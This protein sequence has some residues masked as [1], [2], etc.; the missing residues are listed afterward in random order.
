MKVLTVQQPWA[1][2]IL[3]LGK[4]IENRKWKTKYRG[5]L[6][7]HA[8]K[9]VQGDWAGDAIEAITGK[10]L[11]IP[12][13]EL[14]LGCVV[15]IVDLVD[16]RPIGDTQSPW[17]MPGQYGWVLK[18]P[19]LLHPSPVTGKLLLWD[20]ADELIDLLGPPKAVKAP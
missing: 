18:N 15:G 16:I 8:A 9:K 1:W 19:R 14:H 17:Q 2:A 3:N 6:V 4:D 11:R 20:I 10:T 13:A 5:P 12:K 7:I